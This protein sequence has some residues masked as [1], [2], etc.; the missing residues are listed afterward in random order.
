MSGLGLKREILSG[1]HLEQVW[2]QNVM[3]TSAHDDNVVSVVSQV[4]Q[5]ASLRDRVMEQHRKVTMV[6]VA[7]RFAS[8]SSSRS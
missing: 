2:F 5:P 3:Q 8:T 6:E 4:H 1:G 7:Q